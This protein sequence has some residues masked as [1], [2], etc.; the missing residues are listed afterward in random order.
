MS[1][2]EEM[3]KEILTSP[4]LPPEL[5]LIIQRILTN[6]NLLKPTKPTTTEE[7]L[8]S[9]EKKI[10]EEKN[11][12]EEKEEPMKNNKEKQET[13]PSNKSIPST[14]I[15]PK[16]RKDQFDKYRKMVQDIKKTQESTV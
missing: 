12:K 4:N 2:V 9:S 14:L 13:K 3:L 5:A 8:P 15:L 10:K 1:N 6:W 7:K 16:N 11:I